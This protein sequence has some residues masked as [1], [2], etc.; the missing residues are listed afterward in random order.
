MF[1]KRMAAIHKKARDRLQE[2][3]EA[4]RAESERLLGVFGDVLAVAR[5]ATSAPETS[6]DSDTPVPEPMDVVAERAGRLVLKTLADAGGLESLSAAHEA[7]SAHHGNNYL[8][9]L[10]RYY[11]SHRSA[12]F[13]LL[14]T[15]ELEATTTDRGVVDAVEFIRANRAPTGE[16]IPQT[17]IITRS[18]AET[19]AISTRTLGID[20]AFAGEAWRTLLRDKDHPGRLVRR[21]LEVCVFSYLAAELRSGDIAVLGADSYANL[22][23]QLMSWQEC[24][25]LVAQFYAEAGI[26]TEATALTAF[27]R[28]KLADTAAGVDRGYPHNTD[29]VLDGG[30]PMLRR[31]KGADPVP[32]RAGV[33]GR[34]PPALTR[35][36]AARHPGSH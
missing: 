1:C 26:P 10:D 20:I 13:T 22:H 36:W 32:E 25:P 17:V 18:D 33:G 34:D 31:G 23:A 6:T 5:E 27:Y 4:H 2:L 7:V 35:A 19:G 21:H 15:V 24:A 29:L 14:D 12:L 11:R 16:Y 8:P 9:L 30:R 3:R 28:S